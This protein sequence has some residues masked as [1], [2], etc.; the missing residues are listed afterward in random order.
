MATEFTVINNSLH[1]QLERI[2]LLTYNAKLD[3]YFNSRQKKKE[4]NEKYANCKD[5]R[6]SWIHFISI[7][8]IMMA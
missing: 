7:R 5:G 3:L 1:R 4:L 2:I 6:N 8:S